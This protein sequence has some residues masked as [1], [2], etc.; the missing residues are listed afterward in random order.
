MYLQLSAN[1]AECFQQCSALHESCKVF[2]GGGINDEN[3]Q[4]EPDSERDT[5]R[6]PSDSVS[7][8]LVVKLHPLMH[9]QWHDKLN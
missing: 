1:V 5:K 7:Q 6:K 8:A 4:N 2:I 3:H 9:P